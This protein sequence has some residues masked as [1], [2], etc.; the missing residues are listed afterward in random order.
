MLQSLHSVAATR[1]TPSLKQT[2]TYLPHSQ[3][4]NINEMDLTHQGNSMSKHD[5]VARKAKN[6]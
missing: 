1:R 3:E 2:I 5:A 6:P 4:R